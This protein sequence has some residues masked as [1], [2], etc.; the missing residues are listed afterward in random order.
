VPTSGLDAGDEGVE[1][2][3]I[4]AQ[5]LPRTLDRDAP[6][7]PRDAPTSASWRGEQNR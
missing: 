2:L 4:E 1:R 7:L 6:M 5:E 3:Q